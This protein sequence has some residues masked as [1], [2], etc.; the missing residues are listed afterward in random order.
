MGHS[1][2]CER[3]PRLQA[4]AW[5]SELKDEGVKFVD[6][7]RPGDDDALIEV[8]I[9]SDY[10][11][12]MTTGKIKH[13]SNGLVAMETCCCRTLSGMIKDT[14]VEYY[15]SVATEITSLLVKDASVTDLWKLDTI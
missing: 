11:A 2:I 6:L 7:Y 15:L 5:L 10:F 9:G 4:S 3:V 14:E 13:L 8:H 12:R 1:Q